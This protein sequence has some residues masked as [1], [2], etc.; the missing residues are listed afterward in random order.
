M[1]QRD[2]LAGALAVAVVVT[3]LA[4][5]AAVAVA[6]AAPP[7]V[8]VGAAPPFVPGLVPGPLVVLALEAAP[9]GVLARSS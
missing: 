4:V 1:I 6:V 2:P 8:P 3:E 9:A 5:L 7:F